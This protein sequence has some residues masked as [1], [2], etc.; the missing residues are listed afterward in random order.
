MKEVFPVNSTVYRS[1]MLGAMIGDISGSAHEGGRSNTFN[2]SYQFFTRQSSITD[3][4]V[5]T[6]A[7]ADWL[8]HRET[9]PLKEALMSWA[10]RF[11]HAGY[12][13]GFKHFVKTG[14][15]YH[16]DANGAAMRV[17]PV[18]E[19]ASSLEEALSLARESAAPTHGGG[20]MK[21]AQCRLRDRS[22]RFRICSYRAWI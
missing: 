19:L 20:G 6:A 17:S 18:A 22:R 1:S 5:L 3:D 4:S 21:G 16:S 10:R 15:S 14:E 13:S 9:L 7:I 8:L 2:P 12:G 11:P